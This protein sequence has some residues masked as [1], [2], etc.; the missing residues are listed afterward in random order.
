VT[1]APADLNTIGHFVDGGLLYTGFVPGRDR[2]VLGL[3]ALYGH[4]SPDLRR[5]QAARGEPGMDHEAV[6]ELNYEY[7]VTPWL[8]L[9][10]DIQGILRP[11]GT[12]RVPDALVLAMQIGRDVLAHARTRL[13]S[14]TTT[15][16][17]RAAR[18]WS[19]RVGSG[20][21]GRAFS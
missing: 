12:G 1:Y 7:N 9:Q 11:S 8:Y 6:L 17:E 21:R 10:P 14:F 5:S 15:I 4:F 20:H 18:Y 2:D 16:T 3:F 13:R 19:R